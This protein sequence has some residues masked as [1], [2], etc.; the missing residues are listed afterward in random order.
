MTTVQAEATYPEQYLPQASVIEDDDNNLEVIPPE[1][2]EYPSSVEAEAVPQ[3]L[4]VLKSI[5]KKSLLSMFNKSSKDD[6]LEL[7][8]NTCLD[9]EKYALSESEKGMLDDILKWYKGNK[10]KTKFVKDKL[11]YYCDVRDALSFDPQLESKYP[12]LYISTLYYALINRET[13][14]K[15]N[16]KN[17]KTLDEAVLQRQENFMEQHPGS[18]ELIDELNRELGVGVRI[19]KR[20]GTKRKRKT[21]KKY[22]RKNRQTKRRYRKSKR[23]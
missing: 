12:K 20:G 16:I 11:E 19:Q 9:T 22:K 7:F 15:N 5:P 6:D 3:K 18:A 4:E 1:D 2:I 21:T 13:Q 10:E 23:A 17:F 14:V 8:K